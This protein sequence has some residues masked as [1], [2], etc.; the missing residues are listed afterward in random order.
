MTVTKVDFPYGQATPAGVKN[1]LPGV[2]GKNREIREKSLKSR[3]GRIDKHISILS[4]SNYS[5][6]EVSNQFSEF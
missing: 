5:G 4:V 2:I 6:V 1:G 3:I